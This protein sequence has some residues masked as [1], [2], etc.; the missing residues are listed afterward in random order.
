MRMILVIDTKQLED[1]SWSSEI[2]NTTDLNNP[3]VVS[4]PTTSQVTA[5]GDVFEKVA[6]ICSAASHTRNARKVFNKA[7]KDELD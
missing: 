2:I 3:I 1:H 6:S 7:F 5:I 4:K